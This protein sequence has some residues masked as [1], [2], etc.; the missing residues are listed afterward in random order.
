MKHF[1]SFLAPKMEE[2]ITYRQAL[3]YVNKNLRS[4]LLYLDRYL[5]RTKATWDCL[6]PSFFLEF[7]A[8]IQS[9][10]RTVNGILCLVRGFFHFLVRRSILNKNPL[11][12]IPSLPEHSFIP[13]IFSQQD[14]ERLLKAIRERLRKSP[15]YFCCR[16]DPV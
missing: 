2:Y 16:Q 8:S 13:F 14:T 10:P 5:S 3:G 15:K 4:S 9:Q 11:Q 12:D 6:Q 1:D 7:I